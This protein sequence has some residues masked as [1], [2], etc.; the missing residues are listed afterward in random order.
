MGMS[1]LSKQ[2]ATTLTRA[3]QA[4]FALLLVGAGAAIA[5]SSRFADAPEHAGPLVLP[6]VQLDGSKTTGVAISNNIDFGGVA[7]RLA[8][9]SN[10]PK[11]VITAAAPPGTGPTQPPPPSNEL[12]YLG[13]VGVGASKVALISE[14][15]KQRFVGINDDL[16]GGKVESITDTE[17]R[18]SG[19]VSKTITLAGRG[20]EVLTRAG[21]PGPA[22]A[23]APLS[24][25]NGGVNPTTLQP[26]QPMTAAQPMTPGDELRAKANIPDYVHRGEEQAFLSVR[27]SLRASEKYESEEQLNELA[28]KI[29]E[30]KRGN[31]VEMERIQKEQKER[32]QQ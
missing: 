11:P 5:V 8:A 10:H 3:A 20:N 6:T 13:A 30:E 29:W 17:V 15:G 9:V 7:D 1:A 14:G 16:S 27:E 26:Y 18:I 24:N 21:R 23:G 28:S 4:T 25:R 19:N 2:K 32:G 12:K 31:P 22:T